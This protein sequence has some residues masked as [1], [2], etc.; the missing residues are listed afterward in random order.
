[1]P[2]ATCSQLPP[3]S[4]DARRSISS[5]A[6][7]V[8]VSSRICAGVDARL[9]QPRDAVDERARLAAARPG[10]HQHGPVERGDGLVLRRVQLAGVVDAEARDGLGVRT[11]AQRVGFHAARSRL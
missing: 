7:R 6:L 1:M 4:A 5:A 3:T 8:K 10:D 11:R 9:D 2:P